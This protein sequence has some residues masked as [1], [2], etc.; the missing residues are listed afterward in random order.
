MSEIFVIIIFNLSL[1]TTRWER[2]L[3]ITPWTRLNSTCCIFLLPLGSFEFIA[4]IN[5][6]TKIMKLQDVCQSLKHFEHRYTKYSSNTYG[7]VRVHRPSVWWCSLIRWT[8]A[9]DA[10]LINWKMKDLLCASYTLS[11]TIQSYTEGDVELQ[12]HRPRIHSIHV[13]HIESIF[14][15]MDKSNHFKNYLHCRFLVSRRPK[16]LASMSFK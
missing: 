11:C 4:V 13:F 6:W 1:I 7:N 16:I 8:T 9:V 2:V 5:F 10:K 14:I 12:L 3:M 15:S